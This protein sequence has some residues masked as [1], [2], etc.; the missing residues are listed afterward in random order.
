LQDN[1][2]G[3]I[4]CFMTGPMGPEFPP[5]HLIS[6]DDIAV[7]D[8]DGLLR[9][10]LPD[11]EIDQFDAPTVKMK[12]IETLERTDITGMIIN[13]DNVRYIDGALLGVCIGLHKR[14]RARQIPLVLEIAEDARDMY[15]PFEITGLN[16]VFRIMPE[17]PDVEI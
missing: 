12:F 5:R 11:A 15:I 4:F 3:G 2:F 6:T 1:H 10:I 17:R 16:K 8:H 7:E 9:F 14:L 13:F